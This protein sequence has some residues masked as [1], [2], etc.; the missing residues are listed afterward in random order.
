MQ[1]KMLIL[2]LTLLSAVSCNRLETPVGSLRIEFETGALQTKAG[3]GNVADGG[4]IYINNGTPDL[5]ILIAN[6]STGEIVASYPGSW[7]YSPSDGH[8][9]QSSPTPTSTQMAVTFEGLPGYD[10]ADPEEVPYVYT[11]YAFANTGGMWTMKSNDALVYALDD[12][13][14]QAEVE[15]LHFEP[16]ALEMGTD[17][18][19]VKNSRLP[20]TAKG[21]VTLSKL[22]NGSVI[23]ALKRC[24][25]KVT[26]VFENQYTTDPE[27]TQLSLYNFSITFNGMLPATGYVV[28]H[29]NDFLV[30]PEHDTDL[31]AGEDPMEIPKDGSYSMV[32]YVFPSIGPYSC[33][34]RFDMDAEGTDSHS[35]SDLPVHDDHA[36]DIPQ[37]AR[38]Q[39]LTITTRISA[40]KKVSF[41]F[42]VADW[43]GKTETVYFD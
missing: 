26:A 3:D 18:L 35:Y 17:G 34:V 22:G 42:E 16:T 1:N 28:P 19:V 37:L 6:N 14:T 4:G 40:G 36:R 5:V 27:E 15:A 39:H 9:E 32:W 7:G 10:P 23:L 30:D 43:D 20:L 38:N 33:D 31:T 11:V 13:T 24:V 2:L 25:A 8:L 21:T 29:Q 41:N 12:L